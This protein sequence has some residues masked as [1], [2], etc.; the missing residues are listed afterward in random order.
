M[1]KYL[2][3]P[4]DLSDYHSAQPETVTCLTGHP[5]LQSCG[6]HVR[7]L[8]V[9]VKKKLKKK[10]RA[11][12]CVKIYLLL[13]SICRKRFELT[14]ARV[15][16]AP[17]MLGARLHKCRCARGE[18]IKGYQRNPVIARQL[19]VSAGS[20]QGH[21]FCLLISPRFCGLLSRWACARG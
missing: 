7:E 3:W 14:S 15:G 12:V 11:A 5:S 18:Q 21:S 1:L 4:N 20:K 16:R 8:T 17:I 13:G 19:T 9:M 10:K 6:A 2:Y